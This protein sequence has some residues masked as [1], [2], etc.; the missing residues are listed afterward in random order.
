[1]SKQQLSLLAG[2]VPV[3]VT[4]SDQGQGRPFLLLHGGAG[5]GSM[6]GLA[7]ALSKSG[8]A[9]VPTHPGFDGEPR[10]QGFA[11][12]NDLALAYLA[13]IERLDLTDVVLVGSSAGGWIAAEMALR[14]SPRR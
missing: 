9:I 7:Q 4:I 8:R 11:S 13:L 1:M 10:P 12:I 5:A 6:S 3:P 14:H 2:T